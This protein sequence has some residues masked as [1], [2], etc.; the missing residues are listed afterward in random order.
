MAGMRQDNGYP[1]QAYQMPPQN[2][3]AEESVLSA[4][5]NDNDAILDVLELLKPDDFYKSSHRK[6]LAAIIALFNKEEP[7]DAVTLAHMLKDQGSYEEIGGA[8]F[9][10]R[11]LV[12]VPRS[13]NVPYHANIIK[14]ASILRRLISGSSDIIRKC[15]DMGNTADPTE[16]VQFA[17]ET[18]FQVAEHRPSRGFTP[19]SRLITKNINTL[20]ER[21]KRP[22]QITGVS[23]GFKMIDNML[24]GLQ[25][26][27]LVI[28]AARPSMGKTALALN[29]ARNAAKNG[30]GSAVFSL[31]MNKEQL[32]LRLL[33]SEARVDS[34]RIRNGYFTHEDWEALHNASYFLYE[35]PIFIDDTAGIHTLDIRSR[36]RRLMREKPFGL[37]IIDYIQLMQGRSS[38][39]RREL[40]VSEIS[41]SLK[42]L[43]KEMDVPVLALSQ[44]NRQ[45]EQRADKRPQLSDLRESGALEQDADVVLFIYRDEVYNKD[46]GNPNR[47]TAEIIVAKQR[48]GPVGTVPLAFFGAYTRFENLA[49][50]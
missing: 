12:A 47:G 42:A 30:V 41:R 31:E 20:E 9:L 8:S 35:A 18:L 36:C 46:E 10:G 28:L 39:E 22:G 25:N 33:A 37:I 24:A 49:M 7:V 44:L 16:A 17:E 14:S 43:A 32:S 34:S 15:Y 5:I 19:L 1:D 29:I 45:L 48:N 2:I 50:N 23:T 3:E 6:V 40:E 11:L 27:D 21:Q 26:G 38:A 4:M 13:V